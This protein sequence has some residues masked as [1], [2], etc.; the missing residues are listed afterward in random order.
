MRNF[1]QP[2]QQTGFTL[3]ELVIFIV[4]VGLVIASVFVPLQTILENSPNPNYQAIVTALAQE[5]MEIILAQRYING[6]AS[7]TA[8]PCPGL[9]V[10]VAAPTGYTISPA[11]ITSPFTV[12][13]DAAY[14]QIVV[15]VTGPGNSKA[16]L[17]SLVG[18]Y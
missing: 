1:S 12:N 8:D 18:N 11:V 17:T 4:V 5:R 14:K 16:V 6:F 13:G 3:I 10:C 7:L 15:T 2:Y 9:G